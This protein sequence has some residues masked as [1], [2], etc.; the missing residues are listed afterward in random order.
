LF[1][2][3]APAIARADGSLLSAFVR[4][5]RIDVPVIDDWAM[6]PLAE[7]ECRNFWESS[8]DGYRLGEG[9]WCSDRHVTATIVRGWDDTMVGSSPVGEIRTRLL[10]T[11]SPSH[12][13]G[14]VGGFLTW[15][16]RRRTSQFTISLQ[17]GK[18]GHLRSPR[19]INV[20]LPGRRRGVWAPRD[21]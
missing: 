5:V 11:L 1:R 13:C 18:A 3:L 14:L 21:L 15:N 7:T 19:H 9:K 8:E 4:F 6:V 17:L 2:D 12:L 20:T 16:W 10:A